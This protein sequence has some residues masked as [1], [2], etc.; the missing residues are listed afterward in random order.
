[1][2]SVIGAA[3]QRLTRALVQASL[4]SSVGRATDS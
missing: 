4:P 2:R 1:M 3:V